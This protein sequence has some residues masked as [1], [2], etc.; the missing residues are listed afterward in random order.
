M[1][2]HL[3]DRGQTAADTAA[4]IVGLM[5]R[6]RRTITCRIA[7]RRLMFTVAPCPRRDAGA[8][9]GV[10]IRGPS[11]AGSRPG[12][13][14]IAPVPTSRRR[15]Q[16]VA[17]VG[18]PGQPLPDRGPAVTAVAT[19]TISIAPCPR[20]DAGTFRHVAGVRHHLPDRGQGA[21]AGPRRDA[22]TLHLWPAPTGSR[23]SGG[24]VVTRRPVPASRRRGGARGSDPRRP[25]PAGPRPS[26]SPPCPR[27]DAGAFHPG[28]SWAITCRI[29]ARRHRAPC[30]RRDAGALRGRLGQHLPD[31]G[32][33]ATHG[34]WRW[35]RFGIA[36][37][38]R[39]DAG[40]FVRERD[41]PA[42]AGS[43]PRPPCPRQPA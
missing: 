27:R 28:A 31:R 36:P 13:T 14:H 23:P 20:R 41:G 30:P 43:R 40:A 35:W 39:R 3:P 21:D 6:G 34:W 26:T 5:G 19:I 24:G 9:C 2:R 42:P 38:P 18:T 1:G 12:V 17:L 11:P 25:L 22:G 7:A 33:A 37:C 29:A 10:A 8:F 4:A 16:S 32:R 15:G